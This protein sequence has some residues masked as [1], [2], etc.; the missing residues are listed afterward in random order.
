MPP[1]REG[2]SGTAM[3]G[4]AIRDRTAEGVSPAVVR[5]EAD[6]RKAELSPLFA[7]A[8]KK[9]LAFFATVA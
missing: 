9:E 3:R 6:A 5:V 2:N 8:E 1:G 4:R 7:G